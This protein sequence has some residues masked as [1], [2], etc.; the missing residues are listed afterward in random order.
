MENNKG[1]EIQA[2]YTKYAKEALKDCDGMSIEEEK[3]YIDKKEKEMK[4][5][6]QEVIKKYSTKNQCFF[7]AIKHPLEQED[8]QNT[9][10]ENTEAKETKQQVDKAVEEKKSVTKGQS[11]VFYIDDIV[12]NGGKII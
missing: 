5:E 2:I 3:R 6:L 9:T 7:Y 10:I 1:K 12:I 4:K 8:V 11:T